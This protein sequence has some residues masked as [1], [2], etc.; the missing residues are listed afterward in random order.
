MVIHMKQVLFD[1][2]TGAILEWRDL[3]QFGYAEADPAAL[4]EVNDEQW[5]A[6]EGVLSVV[7]G[8][9]SGL[10]PVLPAPPAAAVPQ[11]VTMR[12]T[13]LALLAAGQLAAVSTAIAKLPSPQKDQAQIE[14]DYGT[15]V[16]RDS[17]IVALIGPALGD[18]A[19]LDALFI[20]ASKL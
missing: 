16:R 6:Q 14:W 1:L 20:A 12:Q 5:N 9:L 4:L 8:K 10:P 3:D 7:K 17:P 2:V 11:D 18:A 15:V 13:R 19:A